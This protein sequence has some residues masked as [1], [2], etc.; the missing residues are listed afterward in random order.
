MNC[1][2]YIKAIAAE[3]AQNFAGAEH[4]SACESCADY[5]AAILALDEQISRALNISVPELKLPQ[6]P[7]LND[8]NVVSMPVTPVTPVRRVSTP[9]WFGIAASVLLAVFVGFRAFSPPA[10]YASLGAEIIAHLDHE[11]RAAE[12]TN[13]RVSDGQLEKVLAQNGVA[14]MSAD[15]GLFTYARTCVINGN[16]IPHLVLQGQNGPIT[17]LLLP[18]ES[19]ARAIPLQGDGVEGVIRVVDTESLERFA[20]FLRAGVGIGGGKRK[21]NQGQKRHARMPMPACDGEYDTSD[22]DKDDGKVPKL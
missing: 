3:P 14:E 18:D 17:L 7:S 11:P 12:T 4:A 22:G 13:Y 6:L 16:K 15:V 10:T 19:I 5:R 9:A 2:E 8:D 21:R 1:E 20:L